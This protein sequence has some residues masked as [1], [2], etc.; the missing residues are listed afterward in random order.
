MSSVVRASLPSPNQIDEV[1]PLPPAK[2]ARRNAIKPNSAEALQLQDFVVSYLVE[3]LDIVGT[4]DHT[5]AVEE[6]NNAAFEARLLSAT[7][8][9]VS[10]RELSVEQNHSE[11]DPASEV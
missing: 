11:N 3:N 4:E 10:P 7:R 2:R 8:S 1:R 9:V 6:K 5:A